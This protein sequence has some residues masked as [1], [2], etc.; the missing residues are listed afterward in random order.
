[1]TLMLNGHHLRQGGGGGKMDD[2][3]GCGGGLTLIFYYIEI[4]VDWRYQ[5]RMLLTQEVGPIQCPPSTGL[6]EV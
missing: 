6:G 5:G 1:M 2:V 3:G 4:L